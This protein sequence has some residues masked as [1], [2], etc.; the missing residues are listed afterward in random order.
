MFAEVSTGAAVATVA[1]YVASFLFDQ[2]G[3]NIL[4]SMKKKI[5]RQKFKKR[6]RGFFEYH[7]QDVNDEHEL[8]IILD[9]IDGKVVLDNLWY[10]HEDKISTEQQD[11]MWLEFQNFKKRESGDAYVPPEYK[12]K[13]FECANFHNKLVNE[14]ILSDKD[15]FVINTLLNNQKEM[16]EA[17]TEAMKVVTKEAT[18]EVMIEVIEESTKEVMEEEMKKTK[19]KSRNT[20]L[21]N[22]NSSHD[23]SMNTAN[24]Y[25]N[26]VTHTV[27]MGCL[28]FVIKFFVRYIFEYRFLLDDFCVELF[29]M[30]IVFLFDAIKNFNDSGSDFA[31]F[32]EKIAM[33][34][35]IVSASMYGAILSN[36]FDN[37]NP[38][39]FTSVGFLSV[40]FILDMVSNKSK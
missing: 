26:W 30:T 38:Y 25:I 14:I 28:P 29:F 20:V 13:L 1:D 31:G 12:E 35:L 15:H 22:K 19:S 40:G 24:K 2:G 23:F 3:S 11:S 39:L 27:L 8:K 6:E 16:T 5:D 10:S 18:K 4:E 7:F 33:V 9:F 17:M 34:I 37:P 36:R 21:S 32:A